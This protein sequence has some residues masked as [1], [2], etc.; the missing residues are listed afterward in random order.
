MGGEWVSAWSAVHIPAALA[1]CR[2]TLVITGWS[3]SHLV[4]TMGT[5]TLL[6]P[7]RG[8]ISR[9]VGSFQSGG[10]FAGQ[11]ALTIESLIMS[12]YD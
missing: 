3:I 10:V 2:T 1:G 6:S 8:T 7:C 4:S 12:W 5:K 9:T 11:T